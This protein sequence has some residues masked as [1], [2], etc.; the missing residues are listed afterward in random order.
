[1][2]P[3]PVAAAVIPVPC[4][5]AA[6]RAAITTAA[7][8]DTLNLAAGCIYTITDVD[9]TPFDGP[10]GLPVIDKALIVQGNG[11]TIERAVS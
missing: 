6:L 5:V 10:N 3:G 4:S 11:A 2:F 1:M 7:P 8:G 9:N